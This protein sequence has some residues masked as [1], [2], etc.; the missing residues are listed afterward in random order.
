MRRI[1]NLNFDDMAVYQLCLQGISDLTDQARL[2]AISNSIHNQAS[3]YKE[4]AESKEWCFI[5]ANHSNNDD[6]IIGAVTKQELKDLYS[7]HMVGATKPARSIYDQLR[8]NAPNGK[9]PFCGMGHVKTLDHY[10]PKAKFPFVAVLPENLVPSCRDCNTGKLTS[11]S[12]MPAEQTLHPYYDHGH[13]ITDQ[14]L[15]AEVLQTQPATLR[16]YAH[17]PDHW[18]DI[19]KQRVQAHL[20]DYELAERFSIESNDEL[21]VIR[22]TL[23]QH[24][25]FAS[26][27]TISEFLRQASLSYQRLHANSWQT[28]MYKALYESQWYC[29]GGFRN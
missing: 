3:D 2:S 9:C 10:L 16:F 27:D 8:N 22:D 23:L 14:W 26:S 28:A 18:D 12:T 5:A 13:F 6:V 17:A 7:T 15:H 25:S 20:R 21:P 19:S 4:K 11:Y 1:V 24:Y 29:G